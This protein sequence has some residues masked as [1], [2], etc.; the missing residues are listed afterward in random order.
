MIKLPAYDPDAPVIV[1]DVG[2]TNTK[3]ATWHQKNL[4]TVLSVPTGDMT[5]FH[6]AFLAHRQAST[7]KAPAATVIGSVVPEALDR[8][9]AHVAEVQDREPLVVGDTLPLPLDVAVKD[10]KAV[11]VDRVCQAA[12]AYD[13]VQTGCTIVSFGTAVTIDLVD[14]E[15]TMMGGAILP[16]IALQ[17]RALHEYTAALPLVPAGVPELPYGT[18]THEAIQTG[19]CRGLAGAVRDIV[20]GYA[21]HLNRWPQTIATGGDAKLMIPLCDFIDTWTTDLTLRGIGLAYT[22]HLAALGA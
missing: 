21:T 5:A 8:I 3:V 17:L 16:G 2:N 9:R 4:K 20:E 19:V 14:D 10:S 6:D 1:I 15:G 11:G 12:A 22:N 13:R 18:D 7:K